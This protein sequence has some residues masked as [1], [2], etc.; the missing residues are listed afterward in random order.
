MIIGNGDIASALKENKDFETSKDT[1]FFAAGVSNSKETSNEAFFRELDLLNQQEAIKHL[2]Y[3][4]SLSIYH[5]QSPYTL[6]KIN[7]EKFVRKT[8]I[9]ST[10]IRLGNI[11]WGTNPNTFINNL[12]AKIKNN[13]EFAIYDEY[14]YLC[15]KEELLHW[16]KVIPTNESNIISIT[17]TMIKVQDVVDA[18]KAKLVIESIS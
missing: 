1:I 13:E 17:G 12:T 18:I 8:F 6:H 5:T 15:S 11:T 10:I 4:S 16:L 3:F 9:T 7:M 2:V 14:R